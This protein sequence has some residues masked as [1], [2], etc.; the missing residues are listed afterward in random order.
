LR[1]DW[2][3]SFAKFASPL[4]ALKARYENAPDR[5]KLVDLADLLFECVTAKKNRYGKSGMKEILLV[6]TVHYAFLP[7]QN[8]LRLVRS[9]LAAVGHEFEKIIFFEPIEQDFGIVEPLFPAACT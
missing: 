4:E 3:V 2:S 6:Y 7:C 8:V 5:Y 9:M 1:D